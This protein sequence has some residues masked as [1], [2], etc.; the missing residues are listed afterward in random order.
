[1]SLDVYLINKVESDCPT[2]GNPHYERDEQVYWANITHNLNRMA[3]E[4]GIYEALWHPEDK[5]YKY[6][7]DIIEPIEM[8]LKDMKERPEFYNQFNALNGWGMY[9]HFIPWIERYLEACKENPDAII[10]TST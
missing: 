9:E 2:C 7:K 1:M 5:G 6:A 8:G 10:E 3:G 4:A